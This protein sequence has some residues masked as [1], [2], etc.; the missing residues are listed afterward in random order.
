MSGRVFLIG[1]GPGDPGLFTQRGL[2]CLRLADVIVYDY[3]APES[4]LS[5]ARTGAERIYVGKKAG[6]H[7]LTQDGINALLVE[8]A[9]GGHTIEGLVEALASHFAGGGGVDGAASR[10]ADGQGAKGAAEGT[11]GISG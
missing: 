5:A 1:S 9:R 2:E 6:A 7:T 4:L 8:R 3:L 10:L 11:D